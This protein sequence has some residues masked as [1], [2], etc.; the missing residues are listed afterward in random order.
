M[1]TSRWCARLALLSA[2][3]S[4]HGD[5]AGAQDSL[6]ITMLGHVIMPA[7]VAG[8]AAW[9]LLDPVRGVL[10][11]RHWARRA[12]LP[13]EDGIA[14]GYG[15]RVFA[16]G[17]GSERYEA[18]FARNVPVRI[19]STESR[20]LRTLLPLD[21]TMAE[22]IGHHVAG[23]V[24]VDFFG[25]SVI[26]ISARRELLR[27]WEAS[28]FTPPA[29]ARLVPV[30][31]QDGIRP[32]IDL[33]LTLPG[34]ERLTLKTYL[35]LGMSG[36]LRLTT[37]FV[38]ERGLLRRLCE[39]RTPAAVTHDEQGLGGAL[40]SVRSRLPRVTIPGVAEFADVVATLAR[41]TDGADAA[42]RWDA[43]AGW[44]LLRRFDVWLDATNQRLW[45]RPT[46]AVA[47][48]FPSGDMGFSLV[49]AASATD[50]LRVSRVAG[51]SPA[52]RAGL[53]GGDVIEAVDNRAVGAGAASQ[54]ER[55]L[56]ATPGLAHRVRIRRGDGRLELDVAAVETLRAGGACDAQ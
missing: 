22:S 51:N 42:P 44:E 38:T 45:L 17:A 47:G 37:R 34:G 2:L 46:D 14:A 9:L 18:L 7:Q 5:V 52:Y 20:S 8:K 27:V 15:R 16:G 54:I 43:L 32:L 56:Q 1:P 53:R 31:W 11:D 39:A 23:F 40:E 6:R 35:D 3:W 10:L 4:A 49:P 30:T 48:A 28:Q 19:G 12:A 25:A 41:E 29:G 50:F 36:P 13:M 26:E 33:E 55:T 21:S 24:G